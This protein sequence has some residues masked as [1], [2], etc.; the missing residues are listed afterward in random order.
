MIIDDKFRKGRLLLTAENTDDKK[1]ITEMC[2]GYVLQKDERYSVE[3]CLVNRMALNYDTS[4]IL[5]IQ[6]YHRSLL[7]HFS[8]A[9]VSDIRLRD[10]QRKDVQKM[11]Q[12]PGVLNANRMGYGKTVEAL[13]WAAGLGAKRILILCPKTVRYQWANMCAKWY[14]THKIHVS[15]KPKEELSPKPSITVI[16]NYEQLLNA[17]VLEELRCIKWD[18]IIA[19]ECHRIRNPKAKTTLALQKITSHFRCGLTGTPIMDRPDDLFSIFKFIN[20]AYFGSSYHN[21][22]AYFCNIEETFWGNKITGLT[23][24]PRHVE[25]LQDIL[26]IVCVRNP[27]NMVGVGCNESDIVL[28][29]YPKQQKLYKDIKKLA[30]EELDKVGVNVANGMSQLIKLQQT[31]SN[32]QLLMPDVEQNIKFDWITDFLD[33]AGANEKILIFSRFRQTILALNRYLEKR[34]VG[35]ATIHGDV[36][37]ETREVAKQRFIAERDIRV[38]SG[39][40]GA[41]GESVDQLQQVCNTVIFIDKMWNPEENN[42]AIG[43]VLR[44]GQTKFVNVYTLVCKGTVDEK[45][46]RVNLSKLEDIRE[47]LGE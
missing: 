38:L 45:V 29:M 34:G 31:T 30:I 28:E 44:F 26:Q 7:N 6:S 9:A 46:G 15:P 24:N 3:D 27:P 13:K 43:R 32:P 12:L 25:M 41:L 42:Q 19:D 11:L 8:A 36:D 22:V 18:V 40:I 17:Q 39:T 47:V 20:P 35:V 1:L 37:A 16:T 5:G 23:K 4:A 21:F 33:D 14:P 10:Y 2:L